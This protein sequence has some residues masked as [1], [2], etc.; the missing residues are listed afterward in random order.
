MSAIKFAM[1]SHVDHGKSTICGHILYKAGYVTDH[2]MDEL[3]KK[4]IDNKKKGW[5]YAYVLD[6]YDEERERGK[7]MDFNPI[8]FT[9]EGDKY[10]LV[11]NAGHQHLVRTLISGLNYHNPRETIGCLVISLEIGEYEA[12]MNGGQTRESVKLLRACGLEHLVI[13]MNKI[14]KF[15]VETSRYK[16]V[17]EA[18]LKY[19]GKLGFKSVHILPVSGYYGDGLEDLLKLLKKI[20]TEQILSNVDTLT[21]SDKVYLKGEFP[22]IQIRICYEEDFIKLITAG[23]QCIL[24]CGSHEYQVTLGQFRHFD[25]KTGK[26]QNKSP[27]AKNGDVIIAKVVCDDG[28]INDGCDRIILRQDNN[29][30]AFGRVYNKK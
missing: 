16:M 13:L 30:I 11:D 14:D 26:L 12:G 18:V 5:E 23:F 24:H 27:L 29:T 17:S 7:T 1:A 21:I 25:A 20:N 15:P 19:V 8:E 4:A 9:Y 6:I 10:C 28:F 3:R 22:P 2:E